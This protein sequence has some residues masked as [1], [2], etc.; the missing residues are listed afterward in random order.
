MEQ[1]N[2][3]SYGTALYTII[4]VFFFWGFLAA[5]NGI[6]IPFCKAHFNLTQFESQLIDFTFYGGYFIGSLGLYFASQ[7][8]KVDILNKLGYKNGII[9]GLILSAAGALLMVPAVNSGSFGFILGAFFVIALGFSL[10]QTAAN[11]FVIALGTPETG[12]NRLN[13]AGG[14]N[15][16]GTLLGPVIVSIVLFGSASKL[17][18]AIDVKITAI[19]NL[20]FILAG[21]YIAVA[22]FFWISKLPKVTSDEK[23]EASHKTNFPLFIIF[24]AFCLVLAAGPLSDYTHIAKA[25]FV[26]ASLAIILITLILSL[27]S[28]GKSKEGWGAMQ[29]PQLIYGMIAI[30]T[31]VGVEVTIQ[32]NMGSLLKTPE[33][34]N[35]TAAEIAPYISL[36]WGSLMI[37]RWTGAI[38]VFDMSKLTKNILT[39]IVPFF[40]F[41]VV[42]FVNY[43]SGT[44]V[45]NL[46]IYALCVAILVIGFFVGQQK[47]VRTLTIFGLL[48]VIAMITGLLTTGRIG[49]FAFIS[50]GLCCSIMWPSIFALAIAGLGKYTSQ[51]SAFLIMMILG[52]SIIPPVQGILADTAQS[53]FSGMSGIHFSYIIPVFGF[54]YLAFFAW[55]AGVELKKQ[56]IDIDHIDASGGH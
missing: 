9:Y 8:T 35:F 5:S 14:V 28:A 12:S 26:Y 34:G 38:G 32:S 24:I 10:Q 52:G 42:L 18:P 15:N 44:N 39:V 33:F 13:L 49:L 16:F 37:G 45:S 30:F 27:T 19:N 56:G 7:I 22:I 6:F 20:Y 2:T 31:Y 23:I 4:T 21:L 48:G 50:G 3:K 40:A 41:G 55:K 36:Y 53:T 47:P 46:Y 43:L 25:Y 29:Y 54:A 17:I 11:P 51:G 1:K